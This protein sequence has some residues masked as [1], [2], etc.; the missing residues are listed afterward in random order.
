[1]KTVNFLTSP[2]CM[3]NSNTKKLLQPYL[4]SFTF[5]FLSENQSNILKK[6]CMH[7]CS[8]YHTYIFS[9]IRKVLFRRI[10]FIKSEDIFIFQILIITTYHLHVFLVNTSTYYT[11]FSSFKYHHFCLNEH[12]DQYTL[13]SFVNFWFHNFSS[14]KDLFVIYT[15]QIFISFSTIYITK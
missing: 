10:Y 6:L 11:L 9:Y 7:A 13:F 8:T 2:F 12:I 4:Y 5:V 1:M 3:W 15:L 14:L